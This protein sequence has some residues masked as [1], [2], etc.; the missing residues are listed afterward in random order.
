MLCGSEILEH[1]RRLDAGGY[2]LWLASNGDVLRTL[3]LS[4][5]PVA[6]TPLDF[7]GPYEREWKLEDLMRAYNVLNAT[8]FGA[9]GIPLQ[10]WVM[11]DLGLLPSGFL[12]I[13]LSRHAAERAMNDPARPVHER[14]RIA[15][16]LPA[17]LAE[18]DRLGYEGPIPV[19]G[20][21]AS[22]TPDRAAWVGWSLCSAIPGLGTVAKGLGLLAYGA[23]T[24]TGVTQFYD[25]ALRV[26]RKF[27]PMR[28]LAAVLDLHP[29]R[30]TMAY[31]T[32]VFGPEPPAAEPTL[33]LDPR[34]LEAQWALQ[35]RLDA[36][37]HEYFVLSPGLVEDR[38]P[39]LERPL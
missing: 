3:D 11:I 4:L 5:G 39:I 18:A 10:N 8:A 9:K 14:E 37:S 17:V 6:L 33:L 23:R 21:C 29:V 20:Y 15:G 1:A 31:R 2:E 26:H 35:R 38:V 32:E 28:L 30:H 34:D 19:A 25:P 24:L 16:V 7:L 36:G 12:L 27:G 22:P 13:T